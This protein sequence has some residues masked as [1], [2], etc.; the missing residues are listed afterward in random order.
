M[1]VVLDGMVAAV[2][3]FISTLMPKEPVVA[4]VRLMLMQRF[5]RV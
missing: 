2:D 5:A 3:L 1:L 4:A